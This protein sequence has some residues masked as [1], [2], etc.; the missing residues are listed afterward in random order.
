[1]LNLQVIG[2]LGADAELRTYNGSEFV[3]FRVAHTEKYTSNGEQVSRTTW[4]DI[5][6]NGNGGGLLQFLKKGK[7]VYVSGTMSL[8]MYDSAKD[9]CKKIGVT[10]MA[11]SIELCGG[12]VDA[13]PS[14]LTTTDGVLVQ[15]DKVFKVRTNE[16]NSSTLLDRNMKKYYA[17]EFGIV[18]EANDEP[19]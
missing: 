11:R 3:T 12:Q 15:I 10:L 4:I 6:L 19:F 9:H 5:T 16:A 17:D 18:T 13:I 14:E 1:M 8:R 7:T 2:N